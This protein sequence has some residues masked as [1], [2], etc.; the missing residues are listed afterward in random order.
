[1][2]VLQERESAGLIACAELSLRPIDGKL[3]GEFAVPP[4]FLLHSEAKLGAYLSNLAVRPP[5]R[6]KGLARQLLSACE[7]LVRDE[8]SLPEIYLHVDLLN[9][10][11]A[12]LYHA[13]GYE[14]LVEYDEVCQPPTAELAAR[15]QNRYHRKVLSAD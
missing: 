5:H 1:M 11:A 9:T 4:L 15:V 13:A 3:P 7:D 2:V 8:W 12:E 10:A 14:E 6:R